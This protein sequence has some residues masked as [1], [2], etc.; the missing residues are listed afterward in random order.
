VKFG[1]VS[2]ATE[3]TVLSAGIDRLDVWAERVITATSIDEILA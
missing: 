2:E 3:Q 1:Q